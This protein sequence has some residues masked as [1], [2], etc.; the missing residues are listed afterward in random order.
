MTRNGFAFYSGLNVAELGRKSRSLAGAQ[1]V[2]PLDQR[3]PL[4]VHVVGGCLDGRGRLSRRSQQATSSMLRKEEPYSCAAPRRWRR[5]IPPHPTAA[6]LTTSA[7]LPPGV[8][9]WDARRN[10]LRRV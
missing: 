7:T 10:R 5:P 4:G 3:T 2:Q 1:L 9:F 6:Y 8:W